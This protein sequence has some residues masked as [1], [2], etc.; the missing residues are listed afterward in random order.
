[1]Y[2]LDDLRAETSHCNMLMAIVPFTSDLPFFYL[3]MY[4]LLGCDMHRQ[5][6]QCR[7]RGKMEL[8]V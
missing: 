3:G 8:L 2:V 4:L 7:A 1:M 5:Q 6:G